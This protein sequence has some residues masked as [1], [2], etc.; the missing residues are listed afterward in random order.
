MATIS[1]RLWSKAGTQRIPL[2]GAFE[3][4]PVCNLRCKMCYVRKSME[5]V[6]AQGGLLPKEQWLDWA[7]QARD[8]GLLFPL[9]TGGEPFLRQDLPEILSGMQAMGLQVSINTNGTLIDQPMAQWLGKHRPTRV[10][11][12]LYGDRAESYEALCG[13]G[14]AYDQ[15]RQAVDW[16]KQNQV[17]VKFSA[18]IT[19]ENLGDLEGMIRYAK[20]VNLSLIHI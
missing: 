8:G 1:D 10:N 2:T 5:E 18:S 19:P 3:L 12:T 17:P 20:S 9:I 6:N 13:N 14:G 15:V 7:R 11:I 4:L 16:L